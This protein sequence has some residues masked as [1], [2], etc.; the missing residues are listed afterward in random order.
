M[1]YA[2]FVITGRSMYQWRNFQKRLQELADKNDNAD[3]SNEGT[4]EGR[5]PETVPLIE[6]CSAWENGIGRISQDVPLNRF[7]NYMFY[8]CFFI[9]LIIMSTINPF[10]N[11]LLN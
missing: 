7:I 5:C 8:Q 3:E 6:S 10:L 4:G 1:T 9:L 2:F 11:F